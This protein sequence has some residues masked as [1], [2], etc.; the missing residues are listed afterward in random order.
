MPTNDEVFESMDAAEDQAKVDLFALF[1]SLGDEEAER[2][3]K[4]VDWFSSNYLAVGYKRLGKII[5]A[6]PERIR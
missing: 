4:F 5:K 3:R 2:V 6:L 1:D